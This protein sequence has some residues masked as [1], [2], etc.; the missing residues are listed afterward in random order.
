MFWIRTRR[1]VDEG[2]ITPRLLKVSLL[3][4]RD[5]LQQRSTGEPDPLLIQ[6]SVVPPV[7]SKV[8]M[9]KPRI[10]QTGQWPAGAYDRSEVGGWTSVSTVQ[11]KR[12]WREL[13]TG[14]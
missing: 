14:R 11:P 4:W 8:L 10:R 2:T 13:L 7:R 12:E 6:G 3:V 5:T 1:M 9:I